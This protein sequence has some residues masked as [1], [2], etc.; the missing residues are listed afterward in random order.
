[1][2]KGP[3]NK[4]KACEQPESGRSFVNLLILKLF[5]RLCLFNGIGMGCSACLQ[6]STNDVVIQLMR[7]ED[8][9]SIGASNATLQRIVRP[10]LSRL[11]L[12]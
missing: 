10:A 8:I 1:M 9:M 3:E 2:I 5:R 7:I 12:L 6:S 11:R 4:N